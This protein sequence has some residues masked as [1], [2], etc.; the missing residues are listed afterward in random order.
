MLSSITGAASQE[1]A[2]CNFFRWSGQGNDILVIQRKLIV[3]LITRIVIRVLVVIVIN[4]VVILML[5]ESLTS[6]VEGLGAQRLYDA[7]EGRVSGFG[8]PEF[9]VLGCN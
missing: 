3:V 7:L 8:V 6:N 9:R 5:T 1:A 2:A 4:V